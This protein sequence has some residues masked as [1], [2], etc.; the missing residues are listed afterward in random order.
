MLIRNLSSLGFSVVDISRVF[1]HRPKQLRHLLKWSRSLLYKNRPWKY[2]WPWLTY[3]AIDWLESYLTKD[4]VVFEWGSGGSTLYFARKVKRVISVEHEQGW[5]E[6]VKKSLVRQSLDNKVEYLYQ[7]PVK[8]PRQ[9]KYSGRSFAQY[10]QLINEYS[11]N[12]FNLVLVD[13]RA[14]NDCLKLAKRKVCPGGYLMLDNSDRSKYE[15]GIKEIKNWPRHD[16]FGIGP[17]N[18]YCWQTSIWQKKN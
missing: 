7:S 11:D 5:Y 9:L 1:I 10:C 16:F 4:M 8:L 12:S 3:D 15:I 18:S 17:F 13:G 2:G 14:R 6:L